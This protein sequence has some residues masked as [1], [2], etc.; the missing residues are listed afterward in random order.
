M[1]LTDRTAAGG[2]R[3]KRA[4]ACVY[5]APARASMLT[6]RHDC[7]AGSWTITRAGVYPMVGTGEMSYDDVREV[8][9]NT[10]IRTRST[11]WPRS[12]STP[13]MA[14]TPMGALAPTGRP[15]TTKR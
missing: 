14:T 3:F 1:C 8:I 2:V 10:G 9:N 4:Y 12:C 13:A 5:C 11:N 6:G 15:T 7:H